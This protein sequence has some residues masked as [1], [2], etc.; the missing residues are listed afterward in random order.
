MVFDRLH[1]TSP[2][3]ITSSRSVH[4]HLLETTSHQTAIDHQYDN[5][6]DCAERTQRRP[7]DRRSHHSKRD[8]SPSQEYDKSTW[9]DLVLSLLRKHNRAREHSSECS[10][11]RTRDPTSE[12]KHARSHKER[13]PR[14][15]CKDDMEDVRDMGMIVRRQSSIELKRMRS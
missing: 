5:R 14:R 7:K 13:S 8:R 11:K 2:P 12:R 10:L 6:Y 15:S 1:P 4:C 3:L 9:R